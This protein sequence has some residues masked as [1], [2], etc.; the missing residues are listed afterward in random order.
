MTRGHIWP[1]GL[2][3]RV[4]AVLLAAIVL[5]FLG[6]AL[7][8]QYFD[9]SASREESAR[10]LAEQLVVADRV[11]DGTQPGGRSALVG[12][13]SS[14][15][16]KIGWRAV[17]VADQR[18]HR[19][20]LR[21]VYSIMTAWE[22]Q[23]A[24]REIQLAFDPGD[25][26]RIVGSIRLE[27]GSYVQFATRMRSQ[28]ESFYL[29]SLSL[30]LLIVGVLIAAALVIRALGS[31]LRHLAD[32]ADAAGHGQPVLLAERGPQDLRTLAR[33]F[34]AMQ[35]RVAELIASRTRAL[36]AMSHDLRTPLARLRLRSELIDDE[37]LQVAID[38]DIHEMERM[39]DS[40]LAY[41][42][43]VTD[44]EEPSNID[45]ASL[46]MTVADDAADL[47]RPVEYA[48]PDSLHIRMCPL[49][50]KRALGN[51]VDNALHYGDR[52]CIEL[53]TSPDGIHLAVEDDG[54]G[55][56]EEQL[57]EALEPFRRLEFARPRNTEGMGLGLSIVHDIV[58]REGGELRLGNRQPTGLRA[59]MFFPHARQPTATI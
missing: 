13:L 25:E 47:G 37:M 32:A 55:I 7:L 19:S 23:L 20:E 48:G 53:R 10:N 11:L 27:D 49:R 51:L 58:Q 50:I 8:Y 16:V 14:D 24:E 36:A 6:S 2:M 28:W 29:S 4:M 59:E 33:A 44:A 35:M 56:P 9:T 12:Q 26:Q 18:S 15:H 45:L 1:D 30:A 5:E 39:L 21:E 57:A 52:A 34:N 38:K 41:L 22:E 42:A 40:V 31:P 43:G 46:A 17:P 54:P 3:G